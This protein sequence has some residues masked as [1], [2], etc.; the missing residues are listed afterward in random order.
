M[1]TQPPPTPEQR[2]Q[3]ALERATDRLV[4]AVA[5]IG[6]WHT[7]D[8]A[9]GTRKALLSRWDRLVFEDLAALEASWGANGKPDTIEPS[10]PPK[11]FA[12]AQLLTSVRL[13]S[14]PRH[15]YAHESA[16]Y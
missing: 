7:C 13:Y 2:Q 10:P 5:A 9:D 11:Q 6:Q 1:R 8:L 16:N 3:D 12:S 15:F 14:C 4:A